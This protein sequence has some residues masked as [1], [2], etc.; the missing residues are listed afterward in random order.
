M[1]LTLVILAAGLGQRFGGQKQLVRLG[2]SGEMLMEYS[3]SD[4][5]RAG[6]QNIV[7]VIAAEMEDTL[8]A[9][10]TA[11]MGRHVQVGYAAQRLDDLPSGFAAP[12]DRTRPWGTGHAVLAAAPQV[13][14]TF[15]VINAD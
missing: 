13:A 9:H 12:H 4:A 5:V 6:F 15:A 1:N 10:V 8:R 2:P 7:L 11:D 14:G 3:I